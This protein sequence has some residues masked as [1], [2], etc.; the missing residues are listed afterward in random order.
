MPDFGEKFLIV[1]FAPPV[2]RAAFGIGENQVDVG[3]DVQ[4]AAA[5]LAHG[6][7]G[8]ELGFAA[9]AARGR[10]VKSDVVAVGI[11][12]RGI[13]GEIGKT[14]DGLGYFVQTAQSVQVA[15]NDLGDDVPPQYPELPRQTGFVFVFPQRLPVGEVAE[16]VFGQLPRRP[17]GQQVQVQRVAVEAAGEKAGMAA[18]MG[19]QFGGV[20]GAVFRLMGIN[21]IIRPSENAVCGKTAQTAPF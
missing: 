8:E 3:R 4:F 10:A 2:C 6:D 9:V 18:G 17:V 14:G 5:R 16:V 19:K 21:G 13:D 12:Q 15:D 1:A 11:V 20:H 7:D